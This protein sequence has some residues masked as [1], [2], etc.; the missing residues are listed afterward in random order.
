MKLFPLLVSVLLTLTGGIAQAADGWP[1]RPIRFVVAAPAGSSLDLI[2]RTVGDKLKDRLNQPVIVENVPGA[3]GTIATAQ[4]ARAVPDGYIMLLSFNGP[5]AYIQFMTK[6]PYDAQRDLQPVMLASSQPNILAVNANLPT[7][8]LKDL[9]AY[10]KAHPGRL[11]YAS[12]GN[13]SSSHLTMELFK[14]MTGAFLVHIPYNGAPPAAASVAAGD[15][16]LLF[17]VPTVVLPHVRSGKVKALAV[18]SASRFSLLPDIPT[19]AEAGM[20]AFQSLAWN[21]VLVPARTPPDIVKRLNTELNAVIQMNDVKNRLHNA[22][23]EPV[24]GTPE[25]FK[26]LIDDEAAKWEPVIRKTK[27]KLD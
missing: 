10:A 8:N 22:G 6:L 11:N 18:T 20:P 1:S 7:S 12:V 24:G 26:K 25:A 15:T 5:L 4:V 3:S 23:L 16:Q 27:A 9:I 2:A 14:S 17:S 19:M 13:G 21:G